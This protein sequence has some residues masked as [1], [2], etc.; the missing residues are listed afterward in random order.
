MQQHQP[1]ISP[2][3]DDDFF[4]WTQHQ[5][6]LLRAVEGT[7]DKLPSGVDI[8]HVAEE[9]EDLGKAELR[10]ATSLIRQI[11]VNLIKA[12]SEPNPRTRGHWRAEATAFQADLPGYFAASMRQVIDLD[13][14]WQKALKVAGTSLEAQGSTLAPG[15]PAKCPCSLDDLLKDDFDFDR[16]LEMLVDAKA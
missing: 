6:E 15:L 3:Y 5:A 1:R 14:L 12:A 16:A 13:N 10:G 2:D 11:L 7:A 9:I 4:A 8:K